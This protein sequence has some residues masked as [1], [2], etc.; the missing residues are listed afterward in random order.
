MGN[1]DNLRRLADEMANAYQERVQ[2]ISAIKQQTADFLTETRNGII[3]IKSNVNGMLGEFNQQDKERKGAIDG[4]IGEFN[5]G[6][7][8]RAAEIS[9]MLTDFDKAHAEM[10]TDLKVK[11]SREEDERKEATLAEIGERK[12]AVSNMLGEFI[13]NDKE[14]AAEIAS[15]IDEFKGGDRE[16][17]WAVSSMLEEFKKENAE[18][19]TAWKDLLATMRSAKDIT[20]TGA[21]VPEA[22]KKTVG[23]KKKVK[24]AESGDGIGELQDRILDLLDDHPDGLRMA[25]MADILDI[26]KWQYLIPIM[27]D[28]ID[29]EMVTKENSTY[30][31]SQ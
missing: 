13:K 25:K 27:R 23:K 30:Y 31:L 21:V 29:D 7:K 26:E 3:D 17:K 8:E 14:R 24:E 5:Q 18:T 2:S 6:D 20:I 11:L 19:T 9:K 22:V 4:M 10:A 12:K 28:L 1:A 15:L 16:R